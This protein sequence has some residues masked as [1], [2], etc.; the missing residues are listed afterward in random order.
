MRWLTTLFGATTLAT[1][2]TLSGFFLG[3][4]LGSLALGERS[5]QWRR[6]LLAFGLLEIGVGLG[7][8]LVPP[9]LGLYRH[10]YPL[11]HVRLASLPAGFA[12]VKLL[13][14]VAAIGIP[15]F[16]MGGTL[17]ALGEA[18]VPTG[19]RLGMP[20]GGL[21]AV[22]LA[23]AALGTLA[24]PFVLLPRLGL[25]TT[26]AGAIS[27]SL[28]VGVVACLLGWS[29]PEAARPVPPDAP[30]S[31]SMPRL[32]LSL[33]FLSGLSTLALQTLWIRMFSLVHENS[34]YSFAVVLFVFLLGLTAG[35]AGAR[36]ELR[37]G[38]PPRALLGAAWC[39][40]GLLVAATPRFFNALTGGLGYLS[41][42]PRMDQ[43][44]ERVATGPQVSLQAAAD[45]REIAGALLHPLVAFAG[46]DVVHFV[47]RPRQRPVGVDPLR[48]DQLVGAAH[49]Q[50]VV[51]HQDLRVED[52]RQVG[53]AALRQ[54]FTNRDELLPALGPRAL[55]PS[56]LV[57]DAAL[58]DPL[59]VRFASGGHTGGSIID[60]ENSSFT[61]KGCELRYRPSP[62]TTNIQ[63]REML[64]DGKMTQAPVGESGMAGSHVPKKKSTQPS[65]RFATLI[66]QIEDDQNR[67]DDD[68]KVFGGL[69]F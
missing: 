55:E 4:A 13:L 32:V 35:A 6:P 28:T 36:R 51:E 69:H 29:S 3:L 20:V 47:D 54:A 64:I 26:Y 42:D 5:R 52:R 27:G 60:A 38:R 41:Q 58:R 48:A 49:Q 56:E 65:S 44:D 23:G 14:A 25:G 15:T 19:K 66:Y 24:V 16:C 63:H 68:D 45:I 57:F 7:A 22:N 34:L 50:R 59:D 40:A 9:I 62:A 21:Y 11:V 37:R 33:S 67:Q 53:A 8:L 30:P 39:I 10:M 12:L 18:V 46:E 1:T 17:P 61:A 43:V 31:V 2:A